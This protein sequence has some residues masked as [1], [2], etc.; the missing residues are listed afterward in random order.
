MKPWSDQSYSQFWLIVAVR[1]GS[2][3]GSE[4]EEHKIVRLK[5]NCSSL[6][7]C[8]IIYIIKYVCYVVLLVY[9]IFLYLNAKFVELNPKV[10]CQSF[11]FIRLVSCN[12]DNSL[13]F[14]SLIPTFSFCFH[15][16]CCLKI[17]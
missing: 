5:L 3:K 16:F 10:I 9:T 8:H 1:F 17:Y 2:F 13:L 6:I 7:S 14:P 15:S 4:E 12:S 11:L